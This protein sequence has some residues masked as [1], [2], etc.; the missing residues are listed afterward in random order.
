MYTN[1]YLKQVQDEVKDRDILKGLE[2]QP[3]VKGTVKYL[4]IGDIFQAEIFESEFYQQVKHRLLIESK[5]RDTET[6][7][8]L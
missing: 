2:A 7:L 3:R 5:E 6:Q 1:D 8:T 4:A